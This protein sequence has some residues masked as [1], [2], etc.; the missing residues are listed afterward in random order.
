MKLF[1]KAQSS[2]D[3]PWITEGEGGAIGYRIHSREATHLHIS[4]FNDWRKY[5]LQ[6]EPERVQELIDH[7]EKFLAELRE[8]GWDM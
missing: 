6:I 8:Q 3:N 2:P 1:L 4:I 7:G 5:E